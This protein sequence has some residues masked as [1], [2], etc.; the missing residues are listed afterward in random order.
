MARPLDESAA[1]DQPSDAVGGRVR[2]DENLAR[3]AGGVE[4]PL[5][6]F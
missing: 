2:A 6:L 1:L 3:N 4:R 5:D